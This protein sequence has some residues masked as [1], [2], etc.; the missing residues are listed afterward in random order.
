MFTFICMKDMND[1]VSIIHEHPKVI[2][3]SFNAYRFWPKLISYLSFDFFNQCANL[4]SITSRCN[5]EVI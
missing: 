4:T 5:D 1:E 3:V 2:I